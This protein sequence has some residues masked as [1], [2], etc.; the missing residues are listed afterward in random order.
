[1]F[2]WNIHT[3]VFVASLQAQ[4]VALQQKI[5]TKNTETQNVNAAISRK[6]SYRAEGLTTK[7]ILNEI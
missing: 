4:L 7:W 5:F 6:T 2:L 3:A 1:M